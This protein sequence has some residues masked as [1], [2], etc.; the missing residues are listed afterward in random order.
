MVFSAARVCG[1][2]F[3]KHDDA[4]EVPDVGVGEDT[5]GDNLALR[6]WNQAGSVPTT[7]LQGVHRDGI[8]CERASRGRSA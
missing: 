1:A 3:G 2:V 8:P 4:G 7:Q 5:S 6:S